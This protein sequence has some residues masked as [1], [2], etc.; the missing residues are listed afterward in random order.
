[1]WKIQLIFKIIFTSFEDVDEERDMYFNSSN[2]IIT[3]GKNIF[4]LSKDMFKFIFDAIVS[5]YPKHLF[6]KMKS[7]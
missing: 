6:E 2:I 7:F 3:P 5:E 1:M 4:K